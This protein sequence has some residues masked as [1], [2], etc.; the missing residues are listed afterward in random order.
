MFIAWIKRPIKNGHNTSQRFAHSEFA[1]KISVKLFC[2]VKDV[3]VRLDELIQQIQTDQTQRQHQ[4]F[5]ESLS[6]NIFN[7]SVQGER[8]SSSGLNGQF[9]HSQLLI[10]CLIRMKISNDER[11]ELIS[12]CQQQYKTNPAELKIIKEFERDYTSNRSLWWYTRQSF[13]YRV[14]NKALRVQN[15]NILYLFRF[16]IRDLG[17]RIR[18]EQMF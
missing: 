6:I 17:E 10:D 5:D 16:L 11:K 13:I 1:I 3:V 4:K 15:I 12:F 2:Q 7:S 18:K 9:V 14:L 8:Q